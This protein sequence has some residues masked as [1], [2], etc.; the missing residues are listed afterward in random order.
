M[1]LKARTRH[2]DESLAELAENVENLVRLAYLEAA[3]AMV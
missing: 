1:Q 3:E 2:R